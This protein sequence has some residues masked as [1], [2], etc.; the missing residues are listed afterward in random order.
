MKNYIIA[1]LVVIILVLSSLLYKQSETSVPKKF[2]VLEDTPG[3]NAEVPLIL[4]VF[5]SKNG[6]GDC[7]EVIPALNNLP[8]HFI[9]RG[10]VPANELTDEKQLRRISGAKFPLLSHVKYKRFIPRYKPSIFGVSP[11]SGDIFFMLPGVPG[12]KEYLVD[13]LESLYNKLYPI[14]L[15]EKLQ[16]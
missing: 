9:V 15:N 1:V 11:N 14:F 3:T 7:M 13:F 8:P 16:E 12:G 4:Y 5:F 2:P 6:C 10:I